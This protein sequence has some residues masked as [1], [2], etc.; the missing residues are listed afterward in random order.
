MFS[1][2][3]TYEGGFIM[4]LIDKQTFTLTN[5]ET[6]AYLD[7]GVGE[8]TIVLIH[9]NLSSSVHWIPLIDA[10]KDHYR[11]IAM[12]MR[13]FGDSTYHQRFDT[14]DEL[15]KDINELLT[16]LKVSQYTVAGW[17]AGGGVAMILSLIDPRVEKLIL[18]SSMS[19]RGLPLYQ[20][21]T[22][23]KIKL[24]VTYKN[25]EALALD[26]VQVAP[27]VAAL[28]KKDAAFMSW[29]WDFAIY[30]VNKPHPKDHE[31]WIQESLKQRNLVDF[32]WAIMNFNIGTGSNGYRVGNEAITEI[33][34]PVL[35]IWG[36]QDKTVMEFMVR[37]TAAVLQH[38]CQLNVY[39]SC[40]H[41]PLVDQLPRLVLDFKK[42]IQ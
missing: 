5:G 18:L 37:E 33:K 11:V 13:G 31:V 16:G 34:V 27:I 30:T 23:G 6:I 21:D 12:D 17:S 25:K 10:L 22:S 36:Q 15:A 24:G 20:K 40:G 9:G 4:N 29:I 41:S 14:L 32:D 42:F 35:S 7:Q 3:D 26:A 19:Y 39:E 28:E 2:Y 8:K 1:L 38:R